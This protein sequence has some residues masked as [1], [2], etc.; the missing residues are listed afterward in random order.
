MN[1]AKQQK[2]LNLYKPVHERFERFCRARVYG[3]MDHKDLMNDTLLKAFE[4]FDKLRSDQAFLSYLFSIST[5]LLANNS[6]KMKPEYQNFERETDQVL[7]VNAKTDLKVEIKLLYEAI[8]KLNILQKEC[9]ILYE[10]SGFSIREV[11]E[12]QS[13]SESAIKQRLRRAR[14]QLKEILSSN[15]SIQINNKIEEEA[16]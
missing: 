15:Y 12:I 9:I 4:S 8:S 5:R 7:D 11:A 16:L 6:R 10:I 13:S 14:L 3:G 2:F 1:K